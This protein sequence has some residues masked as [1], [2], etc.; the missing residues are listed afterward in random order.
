M[1]PK[2]LF[3]FV[4]KLL[5][6]GAQLFAQ[7]D[8]PPKWKLDFET[9]AEVR[10]RQYTS[11]VGAPFKQQFELLAQ[12]RLSL[13]KGEKLALKVA[14]NGSLN[15]R[16]EDRSRLWL[17]E[18]YLTWRKGKFVTKVGQQTLRWG[19]LS[20]FSA[21]D[22]L[23]RY[24]Y[25]DLLDTDNERLGIWGADVRWSLGSATDLSLRVFPDRNRSR[26]HLFDNR[27]VRLPERLYTPDLPAEGVPFRNTAVIATQTQNIPAVSLG[28]D[29]ELGRFSTQFTAY[30]GPNDIPQT[31]IALQELT[32]TGAE[33]H[34]QQQ[35]HHIG[36]GV[37]QLSTFLGDW[38]VSVEGALVYS[39][40]LGIAGE[41]TDDPY[42]FGSVGLDRLWLFDN[43]EQ[44]FK[45]VAQSLWGHSLRG[46]D[47]GPTEL[48]HVF[49]RTA[50]LQVDW[51]INYR[52]TI[53]WQHV[54]DWTAGGYYTRP[55]LRLRANDH[56][57]FWLR[58]DL[59]GGGEEHFFG[60]HQHNDRIALHLKL[61]L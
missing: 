23:N 9:E 25:Y 48:D 49:H 43:P 42:L 35:Y 55:E 20:G 27:W 24:D 11:S 18:A 26:L 51:R 53:S 33:Y 40:R 37:A 38:N 17:N 47:Y 30:Y 61:Y 15:A 19:T 58:A 12:Q 45:L 8:Q 60:Y 54:Q 57:Q 31:S 44:Q 39:K 50:L 32:L 46:L 56:W 52:W 28:L 7:T 41:L 34:L 29:T 59:L 1:Y 13:R 36:M 14:L 10:A 22:L 16:H 4:C 6:A 5:L 2:H 21:L 3:L